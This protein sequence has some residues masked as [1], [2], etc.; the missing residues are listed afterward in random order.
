MQ[1]LG[2]C[3]FGFRRASC[4][5]PSDRLSKKPPIWSAASLLRF[6]LEQSKYSV[7]TTGPKLDQFRS[8]NIF[9]SSL[10]QASTGKGVNTCNATAATE[11]FGISG[12]FYT[13]TLS[14][15]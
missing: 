12:Q 4:K 8:N 13:D 11:G 14:A 15:Q 10:S 6:C 5:S 7:P 9:V 2:I 3:A 1:E